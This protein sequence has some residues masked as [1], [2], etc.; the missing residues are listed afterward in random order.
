MDFN[1]GWIPEKKSI[2]QS[3]STI[4]YGNHLSVHTHQFMYK[5]HTFPKY[6]QQKY[7]CQH[8]S[9]YAQILCISNTIIAMFVTFT[10]SRQYAGVAQARFHYILQSS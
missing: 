1:I 5:N 8:I 3:P 10:E 9:Y 7:D 2:L 6:A 4:T